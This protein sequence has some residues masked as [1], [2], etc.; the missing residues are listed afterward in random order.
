MEF[1][2]KILGPQNG[3]EYFFSNF[4]IKVWQ[5]PTLFIDNSVEKHEESHCFIVTVWEKNSR[6]RL[7][8][9]SDN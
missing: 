7:A 5:I 6:K 9:Y 3:N 4:L 8:A 1:N 2:Q